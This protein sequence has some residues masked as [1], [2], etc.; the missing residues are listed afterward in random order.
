MNDNA[1]DHTMAHIDRVIVAQPGSGETALDGAEDAAKTGMQ[2]SLG[3]D[4]KE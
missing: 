2:G 3:G 1:H 4:L